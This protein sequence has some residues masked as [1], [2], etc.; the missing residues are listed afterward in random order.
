ME[1][2]PFWVYLAREIP[3]RRV[4]PLLVEN[5]DDE[6]EPE[7]CLE[8]REQEGA[9]RRIRYK[10]FSDER[11]QAIG[12]IKALEYDLGE[13]CIWFARIGQI[14]APRRM[15]GMIQVPLSVIQPLIDAWQACDAPKRFGWRI[16]G[17]Q[18]FQAV[19]RTVEQD[20]Q[21]VSL[22]QAPGRILGYELTDSTSLGDFQ[23]ILKRLDAGE[24]VKIDFT[25]S[26]ACFEKET[27][28]TLVARQEQ[29]EY[30]LWLWREA[31]KAGS[32]VRVEIHRPG[33]A[34]IN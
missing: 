14:R 27:D 26:M 25:A 5:Y 13:T 8:L 11:I 32:K 23:T 20:A 33:Q 34:T 2:Y 3:N 30:E 7:V 28:G 29:F 4:K 19:Q 31:V 18:L 15:G 21:Q 12:G 6:I 22:A 24:L 16:K 1:T 9:E 17:V 10:F